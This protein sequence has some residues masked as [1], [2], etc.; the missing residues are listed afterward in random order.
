M[1]DGVLLGLGAGFVLLLGV[2]VTALVMTFR[3]LRDGRAVRER[4]DVLDASLAALH[5]ELERVVSLTVHTDRRMQRVEHDYSDVV[6]R[7]DVVES[8]STAGAPPA[9][10]DRAIELARHGA[11]ADKLTEQFG[12][13]PGEADLVA[14]LHGNK[15]SA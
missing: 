13:S 5:V 2:A 3:M 8:R 4:C 10:V 14:R 7:V 9:S 11:D 1:N 12:L 6:D 15:R